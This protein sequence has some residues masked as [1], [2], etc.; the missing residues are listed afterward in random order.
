M[1]YKLTTPVTEDEIRQI[2]IGDI[3]Y[4]SGR[5]FTARDGAHKRA[6]EL[7]KKGKK[8]PFDVAGLALWHCGPI[9]KRVGKEWKVVSAGSTTSSRMEIYEEDLLKHFP[10]RIIIGKGGMGSKTTL[11]MKK[12]GVIYGSLTG[13]CAALA[14]QKVLKV[15]DV[16]WL[17]LGMPEAVWILQVK[18]LGPIIV[19]I[20][21]HGN[22]M[23]K[24]LMMKVHK[25]VEMIRKQI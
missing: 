20:D 19:T 6:I 5:I 4:L 3:L 21:S 7:V 14:A 10:I 1:M 24:L 25:R 15:E 2:K 23:H 12:L 17:D 11:A 9:V 18:D 22:N 16:K 13:G 8:L